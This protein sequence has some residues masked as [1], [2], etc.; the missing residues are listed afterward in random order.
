M[1]QVGYALKP[2]PEPETKQTYQTWEEA[3]Q[4]MGVPKTTMPTLCMFVLYSMEK[5]CI[6]YIYI[7]MRETY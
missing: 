1:E 6:E 2:H 4:S 7:Y 5:V 3:N